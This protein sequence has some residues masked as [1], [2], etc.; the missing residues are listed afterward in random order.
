[1]IEFLISPVLLSI[2]LAARLF[3]GAADSSVFYALAFRKEQT[4]HDCSASARTMQ[5]DELDV[6]YKVIDGKL[7]RVV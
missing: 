2:F 1:M 4:W 6:R 7:A 5:I 3:A